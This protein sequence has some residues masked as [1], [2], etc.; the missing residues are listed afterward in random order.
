MRIKN[1][2]EPFCQVRGMAYCG[3]L[4]CDR[5]CVVKRLSERDVDEY[6]LCNI[7]DSVRV[8]ICQ[9]SGDECDKSCNTCNLPLKI[10]E[11]FN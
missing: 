4:K 11:E 9:L 6:K 5:A 10:L 2:C 1:K 8:I 7:I 3:N